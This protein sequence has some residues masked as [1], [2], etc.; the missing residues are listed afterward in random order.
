MI[1]AKK[2]TVFSR[3]EWDEAFAAG[4]TF[5]N[6]PTGP[7]PNGGESSGWPK[8]SLRSASGLFL[9]P[10]RPQLHAGCSNGR[11]NGGRGE[12]NVP[13]MKEPLPR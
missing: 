13:E 11:W 5:A 3:A 9:N 7:I 10:R 6:G 1:E 4:P 2:R 12:A 8:R